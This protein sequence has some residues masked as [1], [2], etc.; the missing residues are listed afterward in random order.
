MYVLF[1]FVNSPFLTYESYAEY[2]S[3]HKS[4]LYRYIQLFSKSR[5]AVGTF[6]ANRFSVRCNR[7]ELHTM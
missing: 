5:L 1:Y 4:F 2:H 6:V 3:V 7:P